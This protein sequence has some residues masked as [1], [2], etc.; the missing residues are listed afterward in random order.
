MLACL[1]GHTMKPRLLGLLVL[2]VIILP[3]LFVTSANATL[4]GPYV[5][6]AGSSFQLRI[7]GS[8]QKAYC[9]YVVVTKPSGFSASPSRF[10]V[11]PQFNQVVT[12]TA[13]NYATSGTF[14]AMLFYST[15][16]NCAGTS[17]V[18]SLGW[19]TVQVIVPVK[20]QVTFV[21][22]SSFGHVTA[23]VVSVYDS[24]GKLVAQNGASASCTTCSV[25]VTVSLPSGS[26]K[27][28]AFAALSVATNSPY[29]GTGGHG[30]GVIWV[31]VS[32]STSYTIP[33]ILV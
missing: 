20:Y 12:A 17:S 15:R 26:Y 28:S 11:G 30:L 5:V 21:V 10:N 27:A 25:Y 6:N 9:A 7:S 31:T 29:G 32:R 22:L 3:M 13:P 19:Y 4:T 16:S 2:A 8:V 24:S 14:S 18:L 33:V 1:L 23:A